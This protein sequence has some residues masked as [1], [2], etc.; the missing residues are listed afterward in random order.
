[1]VKYKKIEKT[2]IP[3]FIK[4]LA[5]NYKVFG[6]VK[7]DGVYVF[8]EFN[9]EKPFE[10]K[11]T[12]TMVSAK[13]IFFPPEEIIMEFKGLKV[14]EKIVEEK[15][16]LFGVHPCDI[17]AMLILDK[18]FSLDHPDPYYWARR[19]NLVVIG[20]ECE[21]TDTCFCKSMGTFELREGYDLFFREMDEN[22]Y[23]VYVA[24]E[25]GEKL[26]D[27]ALFEDVDPTIALE[28]EKR[29]IEK[30]KEEIPVKIEGLPEKIHSMYKNDKIWEEIAKKCLGCGNCTM[31]CPVCCC[32]NVVDT[33]DFDFKTF[34]RIRRWD[35]CTL[36]EFSMVAGGLN[37]RPAIKHRIRNWF[38]DKFKVFVDKVGV[39]G[40]VGC[41]RC[42]TYCPAKIDVRK[43]ISKIWEES[44]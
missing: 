14:K 8:E 35:A 25:I 39:P 16:V 12:K 6:P 17:N 2:K 7:K 24:S 13:K 40:C 1:V 23:C 19:K 21:P 15:I 41:G 27:T 18:M 32:F 44:P 11:Y 29:S 34:K 20:V 26:T 3:E 10:V 5:E 37:F 28:I 30:I 43:E 4:D 22:N 38:Y 36:Q 31:V 42:A 9:P 33:V